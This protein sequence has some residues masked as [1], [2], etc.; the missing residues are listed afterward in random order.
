MYLVINEFVWHNMTGLDLNLILC[1][2]GH[3]PT[4]CIVMDSCL[5]DQDYQQTRGMNMVNKGGRIFFH[6]FFFTLLCLTYFATSCEEHLYPFVFCAVGFY[7]LAA[8]IFDL[9]FYWND[10]LIDWEKI[11][12]THINRL[13]F[14]KKLFKKQSK[15]LFWSNLLFGTFAG[16]T[17]IVGFT[18]MNKQ[19]TQSLICYDGNQ[20]IEYNLYGTLFMMCH[21]ILILLQINA[22]Q[23]VLI[24]TPNEMGVFKPPTL[25]EKVGAQ[26]RNTLL[27]KSLNYTVEEMEKKEMES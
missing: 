2:H 20:W 5:S 13:W 10:Y 26:L 19:Q 16:I 8:Q 3:F 22:S 25:A 23:L 1:S 15:I 27:S 14:N 18:M 24:R 11:P 21:Q 7:I 4:F 17:I 6:C 12:P 9:V